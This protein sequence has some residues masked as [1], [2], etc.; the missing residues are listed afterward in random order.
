MLSIASRVVS[1]SA[2]TGGE[3]RG[4]GMRPQQDLAQLHWGVL[5]I[6][7]TLFA[8]PFSKEMKVPCFDPTLLLKSLHQ[9]MY[10]AQFP[11]ALTSSEAPTS[12]GVDYG[13]INRVSVLVGCGCVVEMSLKAMLRVE[14]VVRATELLEEWQDFDI[15]KACLK[16]VRLTL[17]HAEVMEALKKPMGS[18][19]RG[20]I[21][22]AITAADKHGTKPRELAPPA[23]KRAAENRLKFMD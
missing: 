5:L 11:D 9:I 19:Q 8:F 17:L 2:K 14:S 12:V 22:A 3:L 7:D 4:L 6:L 21:V 16:N 15:D 10:A 13:E 18:V 23:V 1:P 20:A